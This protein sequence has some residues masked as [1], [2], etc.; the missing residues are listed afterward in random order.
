MQEHRLTERLTGYW[1]TL[2]KDEIMPEFARFNAS[3]I[4][5]IWQ[6]CILFTVAPEVEDKPYVLNFYQIGDRLKNLYSNDLLGRSFSTAQ[7]HFQGASVVKRVEEIIAAPAAITDSGQFINEKSKVVK[8]RSCVLP[9]GR[10]G[11]VSHIIV[12]LSWREC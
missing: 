9:F 1:N 11:K 12:G 10:N 2:K 4:D 7:R 5:D 8:Y 6:Q 3:A